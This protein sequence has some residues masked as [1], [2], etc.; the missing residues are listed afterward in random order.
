MQFLDF[1]IFGNSFTAEKVLWSDGYNN[2]YMI[3]YDGNNEATFSSIPSGGAAFD[4]NIVGDYIY[5]DGGTS[6]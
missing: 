1:T 6:V 5:Y 2:I 3:G 4:M